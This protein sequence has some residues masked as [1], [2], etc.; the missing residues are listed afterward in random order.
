M[1]SSLSR[2]PGAAARAAG[3]GALALA[4]AG[5][6]AALARRGVLRN[7]VPDAPRAPLADHFEEYELA[8]NRRYKR[9]AWALAAAGTALVPAGAIA[10]A[11]SGPRWRPTLA[12]L[13]GG[14]PWRAGLAFGAGTTIAGAAAGLPLAVARYAWGRRGGLVVQP[15]RGWIADVGKEVALEA[16]AA[17]L[18][19]M[20]AGELMARR[21][22]DWWAGVAALSGVAG[23]AIVVLSPIVVEPLFQRTEP[24]RDR[25][26]ADRILELARL[27]GVP[28]RSVLVNDASRRTTASNAYVSGVGPSR[29]VVL[30]D[31]LLRDHPPEQVRF[32]VAHE[33]AHVARRH[34]M[35]SVVWSGAFAAPASLALFA[36]AGWRTGFAA[37]PSGREGSDLLLRRLAIAG[38]GAAVLGTAAAPAA[39]WLSRAHER[40]AD[41]TA[42]RA[43]GDPAAGA[44]L[45]RDLVLRSRGVPDPPRWVRF[46]FGSHPDAL[47]RIGLALRA[48]AGA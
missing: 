29:H 7:G 17:G 4:G 46:W 19:G 22:T 40:E 47:E 48:G 16:G 32:V 38:A 37:P 30:F 35:R 39:N 6:L 42:L 20:A 10:V 45:Q 26:L 27:L 21:P 8:A 33:L 25:E 41:W 23:L 12:R 9:V 31:T 43:T 1:R 15:A 13:A 34:L 11:A 28:A 14:R 44:A 2:T 24:L 3:A 36:L 18:L 5:A